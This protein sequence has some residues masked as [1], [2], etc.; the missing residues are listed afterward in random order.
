VSNSIGGT[1]IGT[2]AAFELLNPFSQIVDPEGEVMYPDLVEFD[3]IPR[4]STG[5]SEST[6]KL[7]CAPSS[8]RG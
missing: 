7:A 5:L 3:C 2:P 1:R 6:I 4:N 8:K